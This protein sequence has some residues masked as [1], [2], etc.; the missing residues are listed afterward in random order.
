MTNF[1]M[2]ALALGMATVGIAAPSFAATIETFD[3]AVPSGF[4]T[5]RYTPEGFEGGVS[6]LGDNRLKV[7]IDASDAQ[8]NPGNAP[9]TIGFYN[10]QGKKK[11]LGGE[12]RIVSLDLYVD[13]AMAASGLK[14]AGFWETGVDAS[15]AIT[16]YGIIDF[17]NGGF[18]GWDSDTGTWISIGSGPITA[19]QFYTLSMILNV[20][21][22][23]LTYSVDGVGST[24][25]S[26]YGTTR[27][28]NVMIQ[29]YNSV[30]GEN[31]SFYADN[32]TTDVPE[33]AALGLLGL[34]VL[35]LG[36][37]RRRA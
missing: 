36:L 12:I 10:T 21:D 34:G 23:T 26:A 1:R 35:G 37:R 17:A 20:N 5:D 19:D 4:V 3:D 13:S 15:N 33:P 28:A 7:T 6:F 2:A 14:R 11:T 29:G 16:N 9:G 30:Q 8:P 31:Y 24:T 25:I 18:Q 32:L 22:N 27:F